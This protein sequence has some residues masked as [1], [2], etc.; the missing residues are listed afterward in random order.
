MQKMKLSLF[1]I[2]KFMCLVSVK[3]SSVLNVQLSNL[4]EIFFMFKDKDLPNKTTKT[5]SLGMFDLVIPI[6]SA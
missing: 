6:T 1:S 2:V 3:H 4:K 5:F